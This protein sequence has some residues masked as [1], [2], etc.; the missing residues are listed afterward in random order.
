MNRKVFDKSKGGYKGTFIMLPSDLKN[1]VYI[2]GYRAEMSYLYAL[3]IDYYNKE[4]GCAFP[5]IE[6]LAREYGK[7][8]R[9]TGEHLKKLQEVGLIAII[10]RGNNTNAYI[11]YEPL[12]NDELFEQNPEAW[13]NYKQR[14]AE[15][16]EERKQSRIRLEEWRKKHGLK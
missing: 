7:S 11:P 2:K 5:S 8:K 3:I 4:E 6:R 14:L 10:P 9:T 1:Y 13:D 15:L 12:P 16:E